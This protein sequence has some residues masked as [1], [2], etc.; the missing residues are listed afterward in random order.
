MRLYRF[1]YEVRN[2]QIPKGF[3]VDHACHDPKQCEGG[4]DCSHRACVNP[5]HLRAVSAEHNASSERT[6]KYR[7]TNKC[8]RGHDLTEGSFYLDPQGS[9]RCYACVADRVKASQD[10]AKKATGWE[11]KRFRSGSLC[12]RRGHDVTVTGTTPSG[13][14]AECKREREQARGAGQMMDAPT[15][16]R[17]R[18][19]SICRNGHDVTIVGLTDDGT[20]LECRRA[21][22]RRSA[23]RKAAKKAA[24]AA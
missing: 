6:V 20:C 22:G 8:R 17:R 12:R 10:A 1:V 23:A 19:G 15:S 3:V 5:N 14:C 21:S 18:Q 11:D 4:N 9:K 13:A 24:H 16:G 2:G 7:T